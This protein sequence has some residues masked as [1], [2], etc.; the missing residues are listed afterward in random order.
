MQDLK[1]YKQRTVQGYTRK[2][3]VQAL[4]YWHTNQ[5]TGTFKR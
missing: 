1:Q 3:Y 5:F 2:G 4:I